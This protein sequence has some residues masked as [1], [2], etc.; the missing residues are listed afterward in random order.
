MVPSSEVDLDDDVEH[1]EI[2]DA[3]KHAIVELQVVLNANGVSKKLIF[4]QSLALFV[5]LCTLKIMVYSAHPPS[6]YIHHV[7]TFCF[8]RKTNHFS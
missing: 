6:T 7:T 5:R 1:L 8:Q 2:N 4:V 3:G